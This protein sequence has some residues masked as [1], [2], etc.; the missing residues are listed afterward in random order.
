MDIV[1]NRVT[2]DDLDLLPDPNC[3]Y[4]CL[5]T[6]ALLLEGYTVGGDRRCIRFSR[7]N[8][9]NDIRESVSATGH[10]GFIQQRIGCMH[11]R[12]IRLLRQ[13]EWLCLERGSLKGD[14][15]GECAAIGPGVEKGGDQENRRTSKNKSDQCHR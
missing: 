5:V 8:V 12:A 1:R 4:M 14:D 6:A 11:F 2:V 15:A 7:G 13:V 9:D 3:E 10:D